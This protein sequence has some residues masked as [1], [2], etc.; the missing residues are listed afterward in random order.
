MRLLHALNKNIHS[1]WISRVALAAICLLPLLFAFQDAP[2]L[3]LNVPMWDEF[4]TVLSFLVDYR[5]ATSLSDVVELLTLS[6]NEHRMLTSRLLFIV[7]YELSGEANFIHLALIGDAF[8]IAS[9]ALI[10]NCAERLTGKIALAAI[11]SLLLINLQHF[12]NL[13]NSYASIDHYQV[14]LLSVASIILLSRSTLTALGASLLFAGLALFTLAHGAAVLAVGAVLLFQE[15]RYA[16]L[17]AWVTVSIVL[18]ILFIL[19]PGSLEQS[20]AA[21][22]TLQGLSDFTIYWT[23]LLGGTLSLGNSYA[24]MI[25]GSLA[26][27]GSAW[28]LAKGGLRHERPLTYILLVSL[29]A[30][31]LIAYGRS[32]ESKLV[33]ALSSRYMVQ[34]G[35]VMGLLL[36]LGWKLSPPLKSYRLYAGG[37]LAALVTLNLAANHHF[38]SEAHQFGNRRILAARNYD[39]EKTLTTCPVAIFPNPQ[40][41][42]EILSAACQSEIYYLK[43]RP[44]PSEILNTPLVAAAMAYHID[45]LKFGAEF[46]HVQGW[47]LPPTTSSSERIPFLILSSGERQLHFRGQTEPRPDVAKATNR[48]K[49]ID[50]GFSFTLPRTVLANENWQLS[51]ALKGAEQSLVTPTDH[52][53]GSDSALNPVINVPH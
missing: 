45:Q 47:I 26:I 22:L 53:T 1:P 44:N 48:P 23:T 14:V 16:H 2:E 36:W 12:E 51:L 21:P 27:A 17:V 30:T 6:S 8:L 15:K 7:L 4:G 33:P 43:P 13:Y 5:N 9:I 40:I 42:D 28:V 24:A 20:M 25:L 3:L 37:A 19:A 46:L 39:L 31:A 11:L 18:S 41:A 34:S 29:I 35:L 32:G 50:C 49:N 52:Y 10:A 38:K